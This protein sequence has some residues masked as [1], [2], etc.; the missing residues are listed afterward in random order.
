M[1]LDDYL[2]KSVEL[3]TLYEIVKHDFSVKGLV[4]HNWNHILRD[5]ARG[6]VVG[7]AEEANLKVIL[8]SV[9]LHDIGR[10]YPAEG[11]N[12]HT[13]GG[14]VA[15]RYLRSTGFTKEETEDI[16]HCIRSHGLRGLEEP[17][18]LEAKV[19]YDVNVLSC[20]CGNVG[21]A[22]VFH[23]FIA[24]E[25]FTIKQM[26]EI[27]SGRKGPRENFYTETGRRLGEKGFIKASKF[28]RELDEELKE[29]KENIKKT[30]PEYRG[31]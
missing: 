27:G 25:K 14:E 6:V 13:L 28:W 15:P 8:A 7:E 29:E 16:I 3:K 5:L 11:K 19:V 22:R 24:E 9:L 4:H 2:S 23:Y 18:T 17:E 1:K 21:V 26:M 12:H 31:D 20:V 30:I 10:L